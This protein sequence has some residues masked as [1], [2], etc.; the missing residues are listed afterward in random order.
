MLQAL[1]FRRLLLRGG[2]G[3][4]GS[5]LTL[6]ISSIR[7]Y[8]MPDHARTESTVVRVPSIL[9]G[10]RPAPSAVLPDPAAHVGLVSPTP[11]LRPVRSRTS[12]GRS[13]MSQ[14]VCPNCPMFWISSRNGQ[15][16]SEASELTGN[17]RRN[18]NGQSFARDPASIG[19][20]S[21]KD[22]QQLTTSIPCVFPYKRQPNCGP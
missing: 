9:F 2:S 18:H 6:P 7:P 8:R 10:C 22:E 1:R 17:N 20:L 12:N 3:K 13:L 14:P 5:I 15:S 16:E 21:I 4:N 11:C 19:F